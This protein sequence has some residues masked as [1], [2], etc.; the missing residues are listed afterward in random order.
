MSKRDRTKTSSSSGRGV[1]IAVGVIVG[2]LLLC[3]VTM[4]LAG[5]WLFPF[6]SDNDAETPQGQSAGWSPTSAELTIAASPLMA[7][8]LSQLADDFNRQGAKTPDGQTMRVVV[9][10][11]DPRAMVE[12]ALRAPTFQAMSPDSGIWLDRLEQQWAERTGGASTD[13]QMPIAQARTSEQLR[14]AVSPIVIAAWES[15][16]K[17]LGWPD[18]EIGWQDIQELG[19]QDS[20][21]KWSHPSTQHASGL[22]ATLAEFYAGAGVTRGLTVETATDPKTLEYVQG[23]ESTVRFYGE[24]EDVV[25]ERLAREGDSFL[26]AFVA[27]ERVVLDWNRSQSGDRLVA[28]YP[29][30]GSFWADHPLAL[31]ELGRGG[32]EVAVT[33]NQRLTYR[34]FADFLGSADAQQQLLASG[35]RP[36][37]LTI[38]LETPGSPFAAT[39]AVD[40]RQPQT[41]LQI[42]SP[43]VVEIV[44]DAWYY[45]KRPTNVYLVVDTSGSMEGSKLERAKE[46]L[47]AFIEQIRGERDQVGL[48]EF[49]AGIKDAVT[50]RPMNDANRNDLAG[51]IQNMEAN[52]GTALFDAVYVAAR[53]LLGRDDAGAIDALV[54]MTD[55]LENQSETD[56]GDL[57]SLLAQA[58]PAPVIFTIAFGED[59]DESALTQIADIGGGQFRRASETNLEELYR[60]ISTYF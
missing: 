29:K 14:Y 45:T 35:Y 52:G 21:F 31:L 20:D 49:G 36:A 41:T 3:S 55:G 51:R 2:A 26:D 32:D 46:A 15:V 12:E 24:G 48:V 25:V 7:Q 22:L 50:L 38:P 53:D 10:P 30:E 1:L 8:T 59:A 43:A 9:S 54:V 11:L 34:A 19:I 27:Q 6:F 28:I 17:E 37:D 5:V 40:W 23:I 42:P 56:L 47:T 4:A 44:L 33:N 18:E 13:G 16:A 60:I 57:Q 58:R 39:D